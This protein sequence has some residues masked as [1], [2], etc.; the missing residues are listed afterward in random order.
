MY[1]ACQY[2][3]NDTKLEI[4][5]KEVNQP[6]VQITLQNTVMYWPKNP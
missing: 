4:G 1:K 2:A 3:T 6:N 5:M